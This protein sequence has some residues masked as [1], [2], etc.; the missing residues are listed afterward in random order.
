MSRFSIL[1]LTIQLELAGGST[2]DDC[3]LA[4]NFSLM[5]SDPWDLTWL[6]NLVAVETDTFLPC[7]SYRNLHSKRMRYDCTII[8][9]IQ[10]HVL[11]CK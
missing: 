1:C 5:Y 10:P 4:T 9:I 11:F 3:F 6:G 7:F 2:V 8:R